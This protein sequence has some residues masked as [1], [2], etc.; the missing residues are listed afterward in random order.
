M[1]SPASPVSTARAVIAVSPDGR[2]LYALGEHERLRSPC[3]PGSD[4]RAAVPG[5][6]TDIA[7]IVDLA[8]G[9]SVTYSALGTVDSAATGQL[10]N[11]V[12]I[13]MPAGT[14]NIGDSSATDIDRSR[15]SRIWP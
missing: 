4:R 13:A 14:T 5:G 11:T 10:I 12:T 6:E 7:D 2:D 3:S 15:R 8:V 9:G 1:A